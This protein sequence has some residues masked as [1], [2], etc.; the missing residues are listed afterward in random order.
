MQQQNHSNIHHKNTKLQ[1]V[2]PLT[3]TR[4]CRG[5]PEGRAVVMYQGAVTHVTCATDEALDHGRITVS[6]NITVG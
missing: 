6:R 3:C 4:C 1:R 2:V 5:I